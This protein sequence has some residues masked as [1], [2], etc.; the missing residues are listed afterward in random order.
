MKKLTFLLI[1]SFF[2]TS[3]KNE[4]ELKPIEKSKVNHIEKLEIDSLKRPKVEISQDSKLETIEKENSEMIE[5]DEEYINKALISKNDSLIWI[6]A[7]MKRDHR[8]FGFEKPDLNSKRMILLSIF[9]ND[10]ENNPFNCPYGA[11]YDTNKMKDIELKF[12]ENIGN[13]AK[14]EVLDKNTKGIVYFEKKWLELEQD[15]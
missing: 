2:F 3:C 12:K 14:T 9:T 13:F 11:F 7:N 6:V 4:K 1:I 8:I 15:E 5:K 10:V